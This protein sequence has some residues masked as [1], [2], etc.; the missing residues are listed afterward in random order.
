MALREGEPAE[1]CERRAMTEKKET[2]PSGN[3]K[4]VYMSA[5]EDKQIIHDYE[6]GTLYAGLLIAVSFGLMFVYAGWFM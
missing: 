3:F 2:R 5:N 6:R 1:V 4:R